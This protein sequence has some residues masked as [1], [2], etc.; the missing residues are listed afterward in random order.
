MGAIDNGLPLKGSTGAVYFKT[1]DFTSTKISA[2]ANTLVDS[3]GSFNLVGYLAPRTFKGVVYKDLIQINGGTND[4]KIIEVDSVSADG[5]TITFSNTVLSVEAE[6]T[7]I[8]LVMPEPGR[9]I[10]GCQNWEISWDGTTVES[11]TFDSGEDSEFEYIRGA[12]TGSFDKL[13]I[14]G[15]SFDYYKGKKLKSV[16]FTKWQTNPTSANPA[17][18]YSG[19]L[20]VNSLQVSVNNN[21][22]IGNNA[23]FQG[24]GSLTEYTKVSAWSTASVLEVNSIGYITGEAQV[25]ETLTAGALDPAAATVTYQWQSA[26]TPDGTFANITGATSSTY[27]IDVAYVGK[28][29]RVAATGTGL[30]SGTVYSHPTS[31]ISAA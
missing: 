12:W 6:G 31:L 26:D 3:E 2:T 18:Y 30:Y 25:G 17:I 23:G 20:I 4:G 5:E 15:A 7:S 14:I 1:P 9:K 19:S 22:L 21:E 10:A 27:V 28:Y 16:L 11:T 24:S 8:T 13:Y 29:L